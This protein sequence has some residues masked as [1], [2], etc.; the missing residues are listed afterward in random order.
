VCSG[1]KA[2]R[3]SLRVIAR[4]G[5][6]AVAM[7]GGARPVAAAPRVGLLSQQRQVRAQPSTAVL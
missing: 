2:R 7:V 6:I 5:V 4:E 3:R 1:S